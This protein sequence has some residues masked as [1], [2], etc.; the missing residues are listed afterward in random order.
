MSPRGKAS[1]LNDQSRSPPL[2]DYSLR[3]G[4]VVARELGG[5][6][7][8]GLTGLEAMRLLAASGPNEL[9]AVSPVPAWRRILSQFRD[10]LVYLLL[11]AILVAL[12]ACIRDEV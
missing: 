4:D 8:R 10:P 1:P 2:D 7:E 9:R 5:D 11:G 6:A 12:A 3:P